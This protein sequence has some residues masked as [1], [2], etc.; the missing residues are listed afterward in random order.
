MKLLTK[1]LNF[2]KKVDPNSKLKKCDCKVDH[3][4]K[5]KVIEKDKQEFQILCGKCIIEN[6]NRIEL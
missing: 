1:F 3:K 5:V 2:F 4:I 6:K